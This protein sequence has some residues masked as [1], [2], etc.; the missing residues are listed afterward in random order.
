MDSEKLAEDRLRDIEEKHAIAAK[1]ESATKASL[2]ETRKTIDNYVKTVQNATLLKEERF[3][4]LLKQLLKDA[5]THYQNFIENHQHDETQLADLAEALFTVAKISK[6][7]GDSQ[8]AIEAYRKTIEMR[9]RLVS[10]NPNNTEFRNNLASIHFY[11]G[12][13]YDATGKRIE[14]RASYRKTFEIWE[15]LVSEYP[16]V[17]GLRDHLASVHNDIGIFY[18]R[19]G[20]PVESIASFQKA[21]ELR[22]RL[23]SENPTITKYRG[24]L[25]SSYN[26]IGNTYIW[27]G[28]PDKA[29]AAH[30]NALEIKEK[31]TAEN[32]TLIFYSIDL[33]GSFVNTGILS[34]DLKKYEVAEMYLDRGVETLSRVLDKTSR[35]LNKTQ[36]TQA[37]LYLRNAHWARA[38]LLLVLE[39]FDEAVSDLEKAIEYDTGQQR[40]QYRSY[41]SFALA[42]M[43]K[44]EDYRNAYKKAQDLAEENEKQ[45]TFQYNMACVTSLASQSAANGQVAARQRKSRVNRE[46]VEQRDHTSAYSKK[47]RLL[48]RPEKPRAYSNRHGSRCNSQFGRVQNI[49]ERN[50]QPETIESE[51]TKNENESITLSIVV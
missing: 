50:R 51:E 46:M 29:M 20:K 26:N 21:L 23:A 9:E 42:G 22:E 3:K 40:N 32:P 18:R 49:D 39:R 7:S 38:N 28:K 24:D 45:P 11:L 30:K 37:V 48:Q 5:F 27:T 33:G 12:H 8:M 1:A 14:A 10:E 17:S 25:A 4:P 13:L 19:T 44:T 36:H 41:L 31:L 47:T 35:G 2:N 6:E 34:I 16:E 43:A 15:R